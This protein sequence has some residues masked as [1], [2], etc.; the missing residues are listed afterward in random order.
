MRLFNQVGA[1]QNCD[2]VKLA[3]IAYR[4]LPASAL[5]RLMSA[6]CR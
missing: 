1:D 4:L 5:A 6:F 3:T 2:L